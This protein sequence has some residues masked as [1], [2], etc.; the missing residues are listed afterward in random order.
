VSYRWVEH[1]GELELEIVAPTE[2]AVFA[3]ALVAFAELVSDGEPGDRVSVE[4]QLAGRD[5]ARLLAD[6]LDELVFH[7]ETERLV[8]AAVERI[9]L[10][11]DELSA[12]IRGVRGNPRPLVKGVTHH[13]LAFVPAERGFRAT[14]VLDV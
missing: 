3:D 2:A 10:G 9:E 5:R 1:T 12:T 11:D 4:L 8:P 13:R 6:W 14:V 7:A